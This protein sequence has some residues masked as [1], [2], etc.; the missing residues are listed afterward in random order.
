MFDIPCVI[1]FP[2]KFNIFGK[3]INTIH[4]NTNELKDGEIVNDQQNNKTIIIC[5]SHDQNKMPQFTLLEK[6]DSILFSLNEMNKI[7]K[8]RISSNRYIIESNIH[9]YM[10]MLD[11]K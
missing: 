8:L 5:Y 4:I 7:S 2:S 3:G 10:K 9:L 6:N 11:L 1:L